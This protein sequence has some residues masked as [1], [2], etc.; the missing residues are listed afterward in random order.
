MKLARLFAYNV[1]PGRKAEGLITPTGGAIQ[2][3]QGVE[4]VFTTLMKEMNARDP[5]DCRV[6]QTTRTNEVRDLLLTISF[7]T[8]PGPSGAAKAFAERLGSVMDRRSS[9]CL[10][11]MG[12]LLDGPKVRL[13]ICTFPQEAAIRLSAQGAR[14]SIEMLEDVFSIRS[15]LRKAAV[16]EGQNRRTD[17]IRGNV[18]DFQA[19]STDRQAA[20]FWID[21]FL[22]C[23][24]ALH[25]DAGTRE[26]ARCIKKAYQAAESSSEQEA[27]HA[28]M[29]A[30]R[31]SP[32]HRWSLA[33]FADTY[34]TGASKDAFISLAANETSVHAD[35]DFVREVFDQTL[36]F[37]VFRLEGDVFV[38][39]PFDQVGPNRSV[40]VT[41]EN[42][43]RLLRCEGS[44]VKEEVRTRHG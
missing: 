21:S 32:R 29:V 27:L 18:L 26:L 1:E 35:F 14:S 12:S 39:A 22:D 11:V 38:S 37:R 33:S 7:G 5:V 20:D 17:F 42:E 16:F 43:R 28:G 36:N 34:L 4:D 25:G 23:Q 24:L 15:K 6:D 2:V 9:P 31:T 8:G 41:D 13:V 44:V 19:R 3:N 30:L 10:L 40:V